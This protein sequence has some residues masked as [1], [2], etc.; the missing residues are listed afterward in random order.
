MD[1]QSNLF[2]R[3]RGALYA[4]GKQKNRLGLMTGFV[5]ICKRFSL[6]RLLVLVFNSLY[7]I[8]KKDCATPAIFTSAVL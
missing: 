5:K 7:T 8:I 1:K 3:G 6:S 2:N 4:C